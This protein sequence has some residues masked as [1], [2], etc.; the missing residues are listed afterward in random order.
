MLGF[1]KRTCRH[2]KD[3]KT[4]IGLF[5]ADVRTKLE[6]GAIVWDP[7]YENQNL[8]IERVQK[9]FLRYLNFK[10]WKDN[11]LRVPY[12]AL[13]TRF[14]VHTLNI[15]RLVSKV[16][17]IHKVLNGR[18]QNSMFL[19]SLQFRI[20]ITRNDGMFYTP[21]PRVNIFK[22]APLYSMCVV[23]NK[24]RVDILANRDTNKTREEL[25]K[26]LGKGLS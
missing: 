5:N 12:D 22:K 18:E 24:I 26:Y 16:L 2:F 3:E 13:V 4:M 19:Q 15:R 7:Y 17:Y 10:V 23:T 25:Y 6:Y 11:S 21:I 1:I 8:Q 14:G 9:K 20:P